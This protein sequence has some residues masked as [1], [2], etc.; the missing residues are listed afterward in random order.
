[1]SEILFR[2]YH[3]NIELNLGKD[4]LAM[5]SKTHSI[6]EQIGILDFFKTETSWSFKETVK[7]VKREA[8]G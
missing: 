8:I 3:K 4:F 1:M 7:K 2:N 5:I 6:K